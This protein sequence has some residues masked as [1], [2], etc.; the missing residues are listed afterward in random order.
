MSA[1]AT[2]T[3][4]RK[5]NGGYSIHKTARGMKS[6]PIKGTFIIFVISTLALLYSLFAL[7]TEVRGE[8]KAPGVSNGQCIPIPRMIDIVRN[9]FREVVVF[10]GTNNRREMVLITQNPLTK[11]WT[12]LNQYQERFLCVVA[13]GAAGMVLPEL[14]HGDGNS[15]LKSD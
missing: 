3:N 4:R 8:T 13:F 9:Q 5:I 15:K 1:T 12:A 14:E 10:K 2:A 6:D 11:T 7:C